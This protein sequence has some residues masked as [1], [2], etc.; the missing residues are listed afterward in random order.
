VRWLRRFFGR[1][2]YVVHRLEIPVS[3]IVRW[4]MYD[5]DFA[6]QN[7]LAEL[8]GLSKVSKEGDVKEQEDS[9]N[10][11][12]AIEQY[13]P[14]LTQM[15]EISAN[16]ITTIHTKELQDSGLLVDS[17]DDRQI[18]MMQDLFKTI[19]LSTLVGTFSVGTRLQIINPTSA[20]TGFIQMEDT[21]E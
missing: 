15:A 20:P 5:T 18:E 19:A 1:E 12:E 14:F 9:D 3:T 16:L 2:E 13:I 10:R 4:Y 11:L 7:E 21:N 6:D 8:I 17:I